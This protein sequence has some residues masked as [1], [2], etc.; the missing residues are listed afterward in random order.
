MKKVSMV[1]A[2]LFILFAQVIASNGK[3]FVQQTEE[4]KTVPGQFVVKFKAE[5][6]NKTQVSFSKL[7]SVA[8]KYNVTSNEQMFSKANNNKL[9]EKLNLHNIFVFKTD[10]GADIAAIV[11]ELNSDPNIEYAE[12]VYLS[13]IE[14]TPDDPLYSTMRHLPQIKAPEAW[15]VQSNSSGII[16]G[17]LDT[18]V[19]WD[20][21]DLAD[22]IWI[23]TG[24]IA[25]NG[26]DD[27][28]NGYI[29]DIRGWDFVTGVAG[30]EDSDA[31]ASEDGDVADNDPMDF[32]GHG[33]HVAGIAGAVTN[34]GIGIASAS[35]GATIMPLR[36]GYQS[37]DGN[38][39][40]PSTFAAEAY[41]YAAD[42]GAVITNQSSG[43]SGQAILDAA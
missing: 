38:G 2:L 9:K 32:N 10:K 26:I 17:V 31:D 11:N 4:V 25:D 14:S 13:K 36:C 27:D 33:T 19:D 28:N 41:I 16:I 37:N 40:V 8:A 34:N 12:P 20:H 43:N 24:E 35:H 6:G 15:D 30:S 5:A 3:D 22:N 21:E 1:F 29:D 23:N 18:G 7:S 42:N 39:Y